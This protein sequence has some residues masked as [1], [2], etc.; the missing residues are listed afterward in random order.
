LKRWILS[1][2]SAASILSLAFIPG[3]PSWGRG[4]ITIFGILCLALLIYCEIK[5]DS[6]NQIV[7]HS[8]VEI[9]NAMMKIVKSQGKVCIMS[10]DLSWV[11]DEVTRCLL[12]KKD[13]LLIFAQKETDLTKTLSNSGIKIRYYGNTNFEPQTRFTIIGYN[14]N[15]PQVAIAKT[16]Y[17]V[18]KNGKVNHK[19]YQ[20]S[21]SGDER[22]MWINSLALDMIRL[23]SLVSK[24]K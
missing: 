5:T 4:I 15:S 16:Q 17:N 18:R 19:I 20:T 22:D 3:I 23:C 6:I 8:D 14:R 11:N 10:R 13:N 24:E 7:C 1:F 2:S 21:S 9:R 12:K